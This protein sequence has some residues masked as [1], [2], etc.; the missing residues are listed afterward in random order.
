M[1]IA[2][3]IKS[4][5]VDVFIHMIQ[6]NAHIQNKILYEASL[7]NDFSGKA[8]IKKTFTFRHL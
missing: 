5:I 2:I 3:T 8:S 6:M 1:G 4:I 7:Q